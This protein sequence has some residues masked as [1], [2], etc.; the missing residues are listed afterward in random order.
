MN[1]SKFGF[2]RSKIVKIC[3]KFAIFY[4]FWIRYDWNLRENFG[5]DIFASGG[6]ANS[7]SRLIV[8]DELET[9]F[10]EFLLEVVLVA[11]AEIEILERLCH[12]QDSIAP[13]VCSFDVFHV[14]DSVVGNNQRLLEL[15]RI[16]H[17]TMTYQTVTG[18]RK[19]NY[20][21][22]KIVSQ[23]KSN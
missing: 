23:D 6:V 11:N 8:V 2:R 19:Q 13:V 17:G 21:Q 9:E 1:L 7:N 3:H 22:I 10:I 16:V 15:L 5:H 20:F 18:T 4:W 12:F 14:I